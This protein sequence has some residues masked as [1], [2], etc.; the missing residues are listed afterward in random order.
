[1]TDFYYL[2][3]QLGRRIQVY[4][5]QHQ[6]DNKANFVTMSIN[7][8]TELWKNKKDGIQALIVRQILVQIILSTPMPFD[9][10]SI[11]TNF[12]ISECPPSLKKKKSK[13]WA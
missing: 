1:M 4:K 2:S 3:C 12:K 5:L 7:Y 8:T 9:I 10:S 11:E 13:P 6:A